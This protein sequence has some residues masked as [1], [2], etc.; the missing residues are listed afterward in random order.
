MGK[1]R[2]LH[3]RTYHGF[4]DNLNDV[5]MFLAA[6]RKIAMENAHSEILNMA[7]EVVSSN[8]QDGVAAYVEA[9]LEMG[10]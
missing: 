8:D 4:G 1:T 10:V 6:G 7:D 2:W 5:G 9:N 3:V